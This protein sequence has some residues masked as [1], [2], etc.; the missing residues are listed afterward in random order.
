MEED[1][2]VKR[3]P[4]T[5]RL[6]W[7]VT[8]CKGLVG[9]LRGGGGGEG[10]TAAKKQVVKSGTASQR[11]GG[12]VVFADRPLVRPK[13]PTPSLW[14]LCVFVNEEIL[15]PWWDIAL[16]WA[17]SASSVPSTPA[18]SYSRPTHPQS[19]QA[20]GFTALTVNENTKKLGDD[21]DRK[22]VTEYLHFTS[23]ASESVLGYI[24]GTRRCVIIRCRLL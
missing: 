1:R 18:Q 11:S 3:P 14:C 15:V 12:E 8:L 21:N 9:D 2:R 16:S 6:W 13:T 5:L 10:G 22:S 4:Q 19:H 17:D 23:F 7:W 24:S 20:S